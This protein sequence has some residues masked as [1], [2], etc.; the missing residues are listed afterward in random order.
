MSPRR[1]SR[2]AGATNAISWMKSRR[3]LGARSTRKRTRPTTA[4]KIASPPRTWMILPRRSAVVMELAYPSFTVESQVPQRV[5]AEP[6]LA[7]PSPYCVSTEVS[8][9]GRR[10]AGLDRVSDR[11]AVL[12]GQP[13]DHALP[14]GVGADGPGHQVGSVVPE[15]GVRVLQDLDRV[16][17]Q[18][19]RRV[20]RVDTVVRADRAALLHAQVGEGVARH[21]GT[22]R[23]DRVALVE[24]HDGLATTGDGQRVV[25]LGGRHEERV[26][27]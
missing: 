22:D 17:E 3:F 13:G 4:A 7:P 2:R 19:A 27:V 26:D 14:E 11:L 23:V 20:V 1:R 16:L 21:V 15:R 12:A 24:G 5:R 6:S 9:S 18:R 25:R 10:P 8:R